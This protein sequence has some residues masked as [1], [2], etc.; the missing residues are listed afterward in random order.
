MLHLVLIVFAQGG[1][2]G[3]ERSPFYHLGT[4]SAAK[5]IY[6]ALNGAR[7]I[8]SLCIS[9]FSS[10]TQESVGV[11]KLLLFN[12]QA[13]GCNDRLEGYDQQLQSLMNRGNL[14]ETKH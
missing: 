13:R 2:R 11:R 1:G 8:Y 7:I 6:A 12:M 3:P 5:E 14:V 4:I 10:L 9:I